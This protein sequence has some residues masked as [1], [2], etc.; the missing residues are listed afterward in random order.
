MAASSDRPV[1][2]RERLVKLGAVSALA[3]A[4]ACAT[5]AG[6]HSG[7]D[8]APGI[9]IELQPPSSSTGR[10]T[11]AVIGLAATALAAVRD[12][13]LTPSEWAGWFRV[14]VAETSDAA[15]GQPGVL[16]SYSV[17]HDTVQ[18]SPLFGF[19]PGRSYLVVVDPARLP[20]RIDHTHGGWPALPIQ[21]AVGESA[22]EPRPATS[23]VEVYPTVDVVPEN[24]LRL[25]IYFSAPMG[26]RG[27]LDHIHL[28]DA[29]GQELADAFLPLDVALW[30]DDRTR[31]T[32]LFDPGR[33]K[34]GILP[35]EEVG[36]PLIDGRAYTLVVDSDWRDTNGRPLV[37]SFRRR[38]NVGPSEHR[39]IDP[40][41]W[42]ISPPTTGTL[43]PVVVSLSRPLDYA[44]LQRSVVITTTADEVLDGVVTIGAAETEWVFTPHA[45]WET[46]TYHVVA[47]PVLED[48]AGNRVGRPFE[49]ASS[50][51]L[52]SGLPPT[53]GTARLTFLPKQHTH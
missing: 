9:R 45:T 2:A 10:T 36:Q 21:T 26:L 18:F 31:Y 1:C 53:G 13:G 52:A 11:V 23:V 43:D 44:L 15:W 5:P 42:R 40:T 30:N 28:L 20:A 50:D 8:G 17:S 22:P 33:V 48:P 38:F 51:S 24:L 12:A 46:A 6:Q 35:H 19:D 4:A 14:S 49:T 7:A 3:L 47:L 25:Y 37:E 41:E 27:G 16:G 32:L 29:D 39:A 34:R